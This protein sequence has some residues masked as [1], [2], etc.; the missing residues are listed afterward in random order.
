MLKGAG[1]DTPWPN[2][3]ALSAFTVVLVALSVWRFRRQ[4][5]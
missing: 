1:L 5:S 2:M 3:L 4:L